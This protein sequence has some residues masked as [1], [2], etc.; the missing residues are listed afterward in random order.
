MRHSFTIFKV[1]S[2]L[3]PFIILLMPEI[4]KA[5]VSG[6]IF[7]DFNANGVYDTGVSYNEVGQAGV[8]VKAYNASGN[9][10]AVTYTGGG[11]KTNNSGE[12]NIPS[13][14]PGSVRIEFILPDNFTFAS[15][16]SIGGTTIMFPMS[17]TQNLAIN[18]PDDYWNNNSNPNPT[19]IV[20]N[21]TQGGITGAYKTDPGI[22]AF[23][24]NALSANTTF[25]NG[26]GQT[27]PSIEHLVDQTAPCKIEDVGATWGVAFDKAN[28]DYYIAA[29]AKRHAGIGPLGYGGIYILRKNSDGSFTKRMGLNLEGI[30]AANGSTLSFGSITR[31]NISG[32]DNEMA[33]ASNTPSRDLDAYAK[34]GNTSFGDIDFFDA[35]KKLFAV[36]MKQQTLLEIDASSDLSGLGGSSL[37]AKVKSY[38]IDNL[39]NAPTCTGGSLKAWGLKLYKGKGY[40]GVVC[41]AALSQISSDLAGFILSFDP[42][43]VAAGFTTILNINLNYRDYAETWKPWTN[44]F[45]QTGITPAP[46]S[47][48]L[49]SEPAIS[50]IE[51]DENG[52]MIIAFMNLMGHKTGFGNFYPI[53]GNSDLGI[54]IMHGDLLHAC[55]NGAGGWNLENTVTG[56]GPN[57]TDQTRANPEHGYV[58]TG[59]AGIGE[60]YQDESGDGGNETVMGSIGKV[61]GTNNI[62]STTVDPFPNNVAYGEGFWSTGGLT[63]YNVNTGDFTQWA[64]LYGDG[65]QQKYGKAFGLGDIEPALVPQPLEIGNRV[66]MDTDADGEQD[67]GEMGLDGIKIELWKGGSKVTETTTANGGEWYFKNIEEN[68][69]YEIKI[70]A[71]NF[72]AGKT[73][74]TTDATQNNKDLIDND[75]TIVGGD[76]R[77]IY[78]TGSAGQN[79]HSLDFG[80]RNSCTTPNAGNNLTLT[81]SGATAPSSANIGAAPSG[82]I[83]VILNQPNGANAT[84]DNNG[85]VNNMTVVGDYEIELRSDS[86]PNCKDSILITVPQCAVPCPSP[87]C[88]VF[89]V[90]KI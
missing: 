5:Q 68:T 43:N 47:S 76:A 20:P 82:F 14:T 2:K 69:S 36:N 42:N 44:N 80:F 40:L 75:A 18:A 72:P 23:K 56:C 53:S 78:T 54:P 4:S 67:A 81:C 32:D 19:Y 64:K 46:Y 52:S 61:M 87:N 38:Q 7:K 50:D 22:V 37:G 77:I 84:V 45:T 34:V 6:R 62:I 39:P 21:H 74:T 63:W 71:A 41:D 33:E 86:D 59:T 85:L 17:A 65:W 30:T 49:Y 60:Y 9:A 57:F 15:N 89:S 1:A 73:L 10:I 25:T 24:Q 29:F 13:A 48:Y 79:N 70:L 35:G 31:N 88:G 83:W 12:Y 28:Q 55:P 90:R 8:E 66:F 3:L 11:N 51:F 26:N 16:G 27:F 58:A